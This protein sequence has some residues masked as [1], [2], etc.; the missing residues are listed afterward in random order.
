MNGNCG[1]QPVAAQCIHRHT[2]EIPAT[3]SPPPPSSFV[4]PIENSLGAPGQWWFV[5]VT[6]ISPR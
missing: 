4:Q 1:D 5:D 6:S 2:V 3:A